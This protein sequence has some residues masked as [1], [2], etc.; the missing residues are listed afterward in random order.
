VA[1]FI[2]SDSNAAKCIRFQAHANNQNVNCATYWKLW[3]PSNG[4]TTQT[5]HHCI[6]III[7]MRI[8]KTNKCFH[9]IMIT[10]TMAVCILIQFRST[11]PVKKFSR[12][13]SE[14]Y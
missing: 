9:V 5:I 10:S 13:S 12:E 7:L 2:T 11:L 1:L 14:Y 3:N 4:R 6:I 8:M